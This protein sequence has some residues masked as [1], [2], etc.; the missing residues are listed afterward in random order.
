MVMHNRLTEPRARRQA[1]ALLTEGFALDI[2]C[3]REPGDP[4]LERWNGAT[5]HHLPVRRH[6]GSGLAVYLVEY[7]AFFVLALAYVSWL[8]LWRRYDLVQAHNVPDFLVFT[9]LVPRLRGARVVLD[10]RDPL[11][12]FYLSKYGAGPAARLAAA[13]ERVS[14]AFADHVLTPG[15]PSRRRMVRRGVP[16]TKITNVLNSAD[17][18]LFAP[19]ERRPD[20]ERFTLVYHG[21]LFERY[22]LDVA[23]R[24]VAEVRDDIPGLNLR[25]AGYGEEEAS[26]RRLVGELGL[27]ERVSFAGW[28]APERIRDFVAGADLGIAPYR[29]DVFTDLIYPTKAFEYVAMGLPVVVSRLEGIAELFDGVPDMFVRPGDPDDLAEGIRALHEDRG[30]LAALAE[31]EK[32]VYAPLAWDGQRRAYLSVI[33]GLTA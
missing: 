12:D 23:I 10:V 20:P 29:R 13:I 5:L 24:A 32:R 33:D 4:F 30:R 8:A 25:I 9:A 1:E 31:A 18:C 14:A 16:A 17:P 11:P 3:L 19:V 2:L 22:G 26:L 6:R 27:E 21:G 7:V 15:E 28:I